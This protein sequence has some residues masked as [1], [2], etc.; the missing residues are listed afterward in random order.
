MRWGAGLVPVGSG[1]SY[2][3]PGGG[4]G[5]RQDPDPASPGPNLARVRLLHLTP[6]QGPAERQHPRSLFQS[7]C[8]WEHSAP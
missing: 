3:G 2:A 7:G 8:S 4:T 6:A 1:L 5:Q